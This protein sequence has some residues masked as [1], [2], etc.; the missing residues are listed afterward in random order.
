MTGSHGVEP[1][2]VI[3]HVETDFFRAE[4]HGGSNQYCSQ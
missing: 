2:D 3:P 4:M 1:Y